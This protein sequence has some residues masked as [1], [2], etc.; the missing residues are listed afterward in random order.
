MPQNADSHL[1]EK[2]LS[3]QSIYQGKVVRLFVDEV[4][5]PNG[6]QSKKEVIRHG[7][8]VAIV[9]IDSEGRLLLVK[10]YRYAAGRALLE[11]PAGTLEVGEDPDW[12]AIR[13]LQEE[14]GYKPGQLTKLGGIFVAPGY[15]SEFIHLY[16]AQDL[17]EARLEA[18]DDE[19]IEVH[20]LSL[21]EALAQITEGKIADA[22][23]ICA[24]LLAREKLAAKDS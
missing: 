2:Q 19:F 10:Q 23:S 1:T 12:C 3:S 24:I 17:T 5:L 4:Q 7:G 6:K 22:K 11:V 9:P 13:E 8:A 15:T 18:D 21:A 14:T 16:M 20:R